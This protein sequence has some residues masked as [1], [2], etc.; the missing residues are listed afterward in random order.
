MNHI[1]SLLRNRLII[2]NSLYSLKDLSNE[3]KNQMIYNGHFQIYIAELTLQSSLWKK[4]IFLIHL[5]LISKTN[6]L[7]E[8]NSG[9]K[10]SKKGL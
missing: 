6:I 2:C 10:Q 8:S 1:S 4:H 9:F 5:Y 7:V 3:K